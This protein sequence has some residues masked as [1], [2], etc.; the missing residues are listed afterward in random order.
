MFVG[1]SRDDSSCP[2]LR[3][4][5]ALSGDTQVKIR[6]ADI[7]LAVV[8]LTRDWVWV[9][10]EPFEPYL[11]DGP[12]DVVLRVHSGPVGNSS[13]PGDL[14]RSVERLRNVYLGEETWAVDFHP[15]QRSL[16]PQRPPY[17]F[18]VFDRGFTNGDLYVS[19]DPVSEPPVFSLRLFLL[20]L[21]TDM[22]PFHNGM[23]F[24]AAGICEGG[25]ATIFAGPSG[26]GKSTLAGLWRGNAGVRVLND[27]RIIL[28]RKE[29][30]WWAYP[31][32]AFGDL[33]SESPDGVLLKAA[34]VIQHAVENRARRIG[35]AE[36]AASLLPHIAL[37]AYDAVAVGLDLEL[38]EDLAEGVPVHELG[39][40]PD[41]TAV[42]FIQDLVSGGRDAQG[43]G[44]RSRENLGQCRIDY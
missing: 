26:A 13:P 5:C 25:R 15:Y 14:V 39:F 17:Q 10:R 29:G 28:R 21:L 27:D 16:Y 42:E 34:F 40:L 1:E 11:S 7:T 33:R 41:L 43:V 18:M 36:A 24:H 6:I 44:S 38:L 3:W 32:P 30:R 37:P 31:V 22:L 8:G 35:S 12:H 19:G 9:D 4:R 2:L 23:M 20:D